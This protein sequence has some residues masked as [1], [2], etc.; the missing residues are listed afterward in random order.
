MRG[1]MTGLTAT[2]IF[3]ALLLMAEITKAYDTRRLAVRIEVEANIR[4][5]V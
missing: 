4:Q 3:V 2:A 1:N 5:L